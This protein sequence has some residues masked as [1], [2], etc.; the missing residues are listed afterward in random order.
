MKRI[1][2][3][4]LTN[5]AVVALL[6]LVMFALESVLGLRLSAGGTAGL[7]IFATVFGFGGALIS[8]ALSKWVAKRSLGVR[9]IERPRT[10]AEAWLQG[11]V[12]RLATAAGIGCPEVGIFQADEINAF[13]TGARRNDALV[14][15][16]SGLLRAMTRPQVEAV[17]G[18]EISHV[19]NGDMVT[20][21]LLQGVLNAFVICVSR[22]IGSLVDRTLLEN[23]RDEA[24]I[25]FLMV[26]MAAQI[27]LGLG[28]NMIVAWFSR[29]REFRADRGGANLAGTGNMLAAL[30]ALERSHGAPLPG[31]FQVFGINTATTGGFMGL[32]TSHPPLAARIAALRSV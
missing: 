28:A 14:A 19:A 1:F 22:I 15:V 18:H 29:H 20:L 17:L 2:L 23:D 4:V 8:L 21:T 9:V 10:E 5:F 27:L 3:F 7:L 6:S 26:T 30:E 24:G 32:F 31:R 12:R 16:S 11:T 13:A 25:G